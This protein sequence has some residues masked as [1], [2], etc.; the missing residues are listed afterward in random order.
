[1]TEKTRI[2]RIP[3][4]K[5]GRETPTIETNWRLSVY[6]WPR[7]IAVQHTERDPEQERYHRREQNQFKRS[8]KPFSN[9]LE[10]FLPVAIGDAELALGR[11]DNK[12]P[13]LFQ[14]TIV[15][16][17]A[18]AQTVPIRLRHLLVGHHLDRIARQPEDQKGEHGDGEHH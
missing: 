17:K 2:N 8:R 18:F 9:E 3:T 5:L 6:Q 7:L 13:I 10:H 12:A 4:T 11:A 14:H 1:M 16:S 15:Q